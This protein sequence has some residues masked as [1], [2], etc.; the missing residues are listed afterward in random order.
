MIFPPYLYAFFSIRNLKKLYTLMRDN[1]LT[2]EVRISLFNF[3][4]LYEEKY[5]N[6][7]NLFYKTKRNEAP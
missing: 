5:L 7:M 1:Q 2:F 3:N 6:N 4:H